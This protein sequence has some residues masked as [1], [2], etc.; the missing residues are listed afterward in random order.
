MIALT[1]LRSGSLAWGYQQFHIPDARDAARRLTNVDSVWSK[2]MRR[3]SGPLALIA[4]VLLLIHAVLSFTKMR[5]VTGLAELGA[6]AV[7]LGQWWLL[8]ETTP[9]VDPRATPAGTSSRL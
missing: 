3:Y 8:R 7:I 1:V 5:W 6:T 2:T 9:A 4:S